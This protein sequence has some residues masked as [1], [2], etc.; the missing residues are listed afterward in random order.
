MLKQL[1]FLL[2]IFIGVSSYA[3]TNDTVPVK[4][5]PTPPWWVRPFS[6][7]AGVFVPISNTE[8]EVGSEDGSFG[9]TVDLEDDLG[10][11]T[12]TTSFVGKLQWRASRRSRF[13]LNYFQINRKSTHT[14]TKD[15]EFKDT[16]FHTNTSVSVSSNFAIFQ[17]SYSYALFLNPRYEAGLAI[18]AH[19]V[20]TKVGM[21][22]VSTGGSSINQET[23]FDFTAPLP[24]IGIWGG[25]GIGE[26]WRVNG[27]INYLSL[28]VGDVK[29]RI[30]SY[31]A[32]V[33]YDI[34]KNFSA[35]LV[36]AGLNVRVDVVKDH[37]KGFFK[38]GYNGPALTVNYSFG[39]DKWH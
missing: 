23:D 32:G 15:L 6:V 1:L 38:W 22:L 3:Q 4:K 39:K 36:Y 27:A 20:G 2:L 33:T 5:K 11:K 7:S 21:G 16:T 17:F 30:L 9:T 19:I 35:S 37:F 31:N 26:Q 8:L 18:G 28:T 25:Y 29:G 34:L 14:L 12:T 24:D 13:D 10:F